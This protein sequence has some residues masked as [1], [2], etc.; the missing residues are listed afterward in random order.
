MY[1]YRATIIRWIDGDTVDVDID[2]GLRIRSVQRLRLLGVDTPERGEPG[3]NEATQ[4]CATRCPP[5][6][7]VELQTEKGDSFGRWLTRVFTP[8][9]GDLSMELLNNK[10]AVERLHK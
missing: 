6:S 5:G 2:L 1:H 8:D 10:L 9:G 3:Y 7:T 4:Y